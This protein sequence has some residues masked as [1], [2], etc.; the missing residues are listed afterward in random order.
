MIFSD[1]GTRGCFIVSRVIVLV[2]GRGCFDLVC[3]WSDF[4]M[5]VKLLSLE[6]R[7][8]CESTV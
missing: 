5:V 1:S 7:C 8:V 4:R 6:L 3:T 2:A